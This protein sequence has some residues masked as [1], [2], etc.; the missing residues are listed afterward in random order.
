[1]LICAVLIALVTGA[2]RG[3]RSAALDTVSDSNL[4]QHAQSLTSYST[5]YRV[6]PHFTQIGWGVATIEGPHISV[7]L[8]SYFDAHHTWHLILAE[9]YY[10]VSETSDVFFPPRFKEDSGGGYPSYTPYHY[11]CVFIASPE[12]WN[13][14]TRMG[15]TQYR[16]TRPDEVLYP[17]R[18]ALVSES[19]PYVPRAMERTGLDG[20][21]LPVA[22]IDGSARGI[23]PEHRN[24]GYERGDGFQFQDSGAVHMIDWPPTLHTFDGAR[25]RDVR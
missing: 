15:P 3:A 4:R 10:S 18:K 2:L 11:G 6:W 8:V 22:F 23:K 1:M 25:G 9:P 19:W 13:P 20:P 17:S 14:R 7:P 5:D 16:A 12:Y 24:N 21:A